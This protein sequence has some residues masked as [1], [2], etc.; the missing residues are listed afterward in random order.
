MVGAPSVIHGGHVL[1]SH[2]P[3]FGVARIR[4]VE[5]LGLLIVKVGL[6]H[7]ATPAGLDALLL[8]VEASEHEEQGATAKEAESD[9]YRHEADD[10]AARALAIGG[11]LGDERSLASALF[12]FGHSHTSVP[13]RTTMARPGE[14][15]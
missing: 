5:E 9:N 3:A 13:S 6:K 1:P 4:G 10:D 11:K 15:S 14:G 2:A 7:L 12:W 8:A